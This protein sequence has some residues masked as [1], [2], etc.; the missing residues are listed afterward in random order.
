MKKLLLFLMVLV[1]GAAM[2]LQAQV[3]QYEDVVYL[4]NS[5]IVR[6]II[7]EQIPN[8]SL[9]IQTRED[10]VFVYKMD[11]VEKITKELSSQKG[12]FQIDS[13]KQINE[14]V[15]HLKNGSVIKGIIIEQIPNVSIKI[16]TRE[17]N[18]FVYKMDEVEKITKE[19]SQQ[20]GKTL[21]N[22]SKQSREYSH[23]NKPKGYLGLIEIEGGLGFGRWQAD[24]FSISLINGYR[25]MPQFAFGIG[26]GSR[27]FSF[28][29]E[30][31]GNG[32]GRETSWS[33]PF[34]LHL[35]SDFLASKKVS[36]YISFNVGYN[37][38]LSYNNRNISFGGLL[39]EPS[40]GVGFNIGETNSRVNFGL[41]FPINRAQ[42]RV[43]SGYDY[44]YSYANGYGGAVNLEVGF[45]F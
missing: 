30:T 27:M 2:S 45:S 43:A 44:N 12:K 25:P 22:V 37:L 17:D 16:K 13:Q 28:F 31:V 24:R 21:I 23:F 11:E 39:I 33:M 10:N 26:I 8:E 41:S 6:G 14:D 20:K 4:K 42:Y 7:I 40:I 15:M 18:I 1:A 29:Y 38:N 35:R 3:Q 19:L 34:F 36:P 5:S 9:K 32:R